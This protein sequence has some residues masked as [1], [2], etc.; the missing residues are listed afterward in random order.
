MTI[1]YN[2]DLL[3]SKMI[4]LYE[5]AI[6]EYIEENNTEESYEDTLNDIY[7]D[8]SVCGQDRPQ[9]TLLK[10]IDPIAFRV[11]MSENED[12][13]RDQA[14]NEISKDDFRDQA[15]EDLDMRDQE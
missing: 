6:E 9:G 7:G 11:G 3:Y 13:I 14:E 2:E 12:H 5:L 10:E 15:L 8:A 4:D 1:L